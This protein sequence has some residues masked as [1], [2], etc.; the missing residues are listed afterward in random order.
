MK[1]VDINKGD[2]AHPEYR[3]R[4]GGKEVKLD[5]RKN[6]FAATPPPG[7]QEVLLSYAVTEGIGYLPGDM[8]GDTKLDFIDISSAYFQ[9]DGI[10]GVHEVLPLEDHEQGTCGRLR[11]SC[12]AQEMRLR[13]GAKS[14]CDSWRNPA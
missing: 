3:S 10:G 14:T 2:G 4:L 6:L 1:W 7:S 5:K 11:K 9:A 13:T 8:E 12:M